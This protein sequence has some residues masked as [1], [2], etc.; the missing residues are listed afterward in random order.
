MHM[1]ASLRTLLAISWWALPLAFAV[2]AWLLYRQRDRQGVKLIAW[3]ALVVVVGLGATA[4]SFLLGAS[5]A[6]HGNASLSVALTS[7]LGCVFT[8]YLPSLQYY[9]PWPSVQFVLLPV[10][11]LLLGIVTARRSWR[12]RDRTRES[13][14]LLA[15][16]FSRSTLSAAMHRFLW[17]AIPVAFLWFP[18]INSPDL[19]AMKPLF[20]FLV[21]LLLVAAGLLLVALVA[22]WFRVL[23]N[24]I[25]AL[26]FLLFSLYFLIGLLMAGFAP[27][28]PDISV[29]SVIRAQNLSLALAYV[30][31][32]LL[33][34]A[35]SAIFKIRS[36]ATPEH[37]NARQ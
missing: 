7:T 18:L 4:A 6:P 12:N 36:A 19:D 28:G 29:S 16:L 13:A 31:L 5:Y 3:F 23:P 22:R 34:A 20:M 32:V 17:P 26:L 27:H 11:Y 1:A 24:L 14:S 37:P 9:C 8:P 25:G 21:L 33:G 35:I 15:R 10:I 2:C 30:G